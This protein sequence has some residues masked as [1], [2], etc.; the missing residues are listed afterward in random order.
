MMFFSKK[1]AVYPLKNQDSVSTAA[2]LEKIFKEDIGLPLQVYND[3]GGEFVKHFAEKLK[4]YDVEQKT[5]RTPPAF[6]ERAI[7]TVKEKIEKRQEAL[8]IAKWQDALPY[9]VK[10]YN[11]EEH[12]TTG[13]TPNYAATA[14][15]EDIV[16]K[17]IQE[18]A[19]FNKK[20][21]PIKENDQVRVFKK[22][23]KY[24][25][26]GFDFD[27]YKP[28]NERVQGFD[29]DRSSTRTYK[30]SNIARPLMRHELKLIR[31]SE[32]PVLVQRR[33][34]KKGA[35]RYKAA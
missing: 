3:E 30:L 2:A 8:K 34:G 19:S 11:D 15:Y 32:T 13:V 20:Y 18:K 21:E 6:V 33:L 16:K 24:S 25:E 14:K 7:R 35:L 1:L 10:Q 17:N 5:S 28:G 29:A 4:Y 9:V 23:G 22:P 31:G 27:H 12:T 26:F